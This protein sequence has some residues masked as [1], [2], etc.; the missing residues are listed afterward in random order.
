M[1]QL[2]DF[3][4]ELALYESD[5]ISCTKAQPINDTQETTLVRLIALT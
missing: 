1:S 2:D 3:P 4:V 5:A